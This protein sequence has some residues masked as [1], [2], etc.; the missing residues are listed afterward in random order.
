MNKK[1]VRDID[2]RNKRVLVRVDF[3]VPLDGEGRITDRTRIEAAL[4]TIQY[5]LEQPAAVIL[6]SHLGRPKG[7]DEG[8]RLNVVADALSE[9]LGRPVKKVDDCVGPE[10]KAAAEALQPGE[11]L[12]LENLR[13]HKEETE[14]DPAF[15]QELASLADVYVNDAFGAAHRAH[16]STEG[17]TRYLPAVAGFLVAKEI[18]VIGGALE[19]PERPFVAVLG[20]AKVKDKIGVI[21]N[22]LTKVDVLLVGGGMAYTFLKAKGYEVGRSL[23]DSERIELAAELMKEAEA[24]GVRFLLPVDIVV[25]DDFR[26]DA[27]TQVVPADGIPADWEGLDI[28]PETRK[29]FAAEIEAAK[30][31]IWNGPL[32]AFEMPAFAEGTRS[33]AEA[34]ARTKAKT[35]I[36]GGDS[37]AA[38]Q[39]FGLAGAMDHISTGGGASLEFIEG[40]VLPGIAALQDKE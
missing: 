26:N 40:K 14:N 29:L 25:A 35:I 37:A 8:L 6:M 1:S 28:G 3:N 11:V 16:A 34:M 38:V 2:V 19:N 22:L 15:A 39:Q 5:L 30:T 33:I 32:G 36:G 21:R 20:G 31:V 17:V 23:L 4:P 10:V 7:V 18:E 27:A 24:R 9:L 12:L 13:F